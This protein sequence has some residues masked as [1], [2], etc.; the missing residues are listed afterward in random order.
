MNLTF[1]KN[2]R[3]GGPGLIGDYALERGWS[4][5]QVIDFKDASCHAA[6]PLKDDVVVF[7]GSPRSAFEMGE[8]WIAHEF[9]LMRR[10]LALGTP[11]LGVCFGAQLLARV[12]GGEVRPM[13]RAFRGWHG[14]DEV[15]H[16]VWRGPWLRW[17]RD[18]IF[19][20]DGM[21]VLAASD[22]IVQAFKTGRAVGVQF[23]PEATLEILR[24]WIA[25][26]NGDTPRDALLRAE[27]V[28]TSD[29][30]AVRQRSYT[31]MDHIFDEII[32]GQSPE[33]DGDRC[34]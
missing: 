13:D 7:L 24:D 4:I 8:P 34:S 18:R 17:H 27:A 15:S 33:A 23:H 12:V 11:M 21:R 6:A 22:G 30:A 25:A 20:P 28:M 19:L 1:F 32:D 31:L 2:S 9:D 5:R 16:A 3:G 26:A 29:A 14:N 10:L